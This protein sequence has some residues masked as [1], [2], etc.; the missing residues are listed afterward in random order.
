MEDEDH[1][2]VGRR[3]VPALQLYSIWR[4]Q[5]NYLKPFWRAGHRCSGREY[6]QYAHSRRKAQ[7]QQHDQGNQSNSKNA[8]DT[9]ED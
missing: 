7:I 8:Q 4:A 6:S 5:S 2:A 9:L 3:P 1:R